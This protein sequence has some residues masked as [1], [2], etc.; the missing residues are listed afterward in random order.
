MESLARLSQ[1]ATKYPAMV[2][3]CARMMADAAREYVK[4]WTTDFI[5]ILSAAL[6]S[7]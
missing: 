6:R 4:L 1:L 5:T 7:K 2:V 3:E